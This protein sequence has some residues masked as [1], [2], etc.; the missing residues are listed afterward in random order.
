MYQLLVHS[1]LHVVLS[2]V[3]IQFTSFLFLLHEA[4]NCTECILSSWRYL[5]NQW[6]IVLKSIRIQLTPGSCAQGVKYY[7]V[8]SCIH[9]N[10]ILWLLLVA[11]CSIGHAK[12]TGH[13]SFAAATSAF[14]LGWYY[15]SWQSSLSLVMAIH[16]AHVKW[17]RALGTLSA[18]TRQLHNNRHTR[19]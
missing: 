13:V 1:G 9:Q 12:S 4:L 10:H 5:S 3:Q 19:G 2:R 16:L 8:H 15:L 7:V 14:V 17:I 18:H 11:V 6:L